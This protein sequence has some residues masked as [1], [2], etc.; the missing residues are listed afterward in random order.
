MVA[1]CK[2]F[3]RRRVENAYFCTRRASF[4][5]GGAMMEKKPRPKATPAPS[6]CFDPQGS[7]TGVPTDGSTHPTQDA[8]DL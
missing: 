4:C 3:L 1:D 2:I 6:P 8:D 7:Y 5:K